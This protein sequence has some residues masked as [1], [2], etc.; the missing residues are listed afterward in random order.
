VDFVDERIVLPLLWFLFAAL[1]ASAIGVIAGQMK[2]LLL[3]AV[4]YVGLMIVPG[5]VN[6]VY[7]RPNEISLQRPY[8]QR[9]I[10]ATRRAFGLSKRVQETEFPARLEARIDIARHRPLIDNVRLWDWR[11]FLTPRRKFII[12]PYYA[13]PD[14][15]VDRHH[16]RPIAAGVVEPRVDI[17]QRAQGLDQPLHL[18]TATEW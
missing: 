4:A 10:E 13:F 6:A 8:I 18:R 14:T 7:V 11:A 5:G 12:R 1:I 9:H 2:A 3:P 15:D 17:R 16:R